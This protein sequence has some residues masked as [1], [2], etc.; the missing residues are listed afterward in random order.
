M[1][2]KLRAKLYEI[3]EE[4][5]QT[6][7]RDAPQPDRVGRSLGEDPHLQLRRMLTIA[8]RADAPQPPWRAD[9][10]RRRHRHLRAHSKAQA[11]AA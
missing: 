9:G 3:E 6:A 5:R 1:A 11:A 10:I 2:M 4:K 7:E 8:D